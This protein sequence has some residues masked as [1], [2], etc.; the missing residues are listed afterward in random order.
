[1]LTKICD[2]E[3]I[4]NIYFHQI[5]VLIKHGYMWVMHETYIYSFEKAVRK[6]N[7][8]FNVKLG[9]PRSKIMVLLNSLEECNSE[10]LK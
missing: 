1:M 5:S 4:K 7:A 2:L 8:I 3:V 10:R 6:P 9:F